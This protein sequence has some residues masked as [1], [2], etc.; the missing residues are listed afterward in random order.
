MASSKKTEDFIC[1]QGT[2]KYAN[3]FKIKQVPS[4]LFS[5]F[6]GDEILRAPILSD[7]SLE[8]AMEAALKKY[9]DQPVPWKT[10]CAPENGAKKLL[11]VGF[12]DDEK[13]EGLK[14][15]EDRSLVK[16]RD[17][18]VFLRLPG[19]K[20]SEAVKKWNLYQA[21]S[22]VLADASK[23]DPEKSPFER[24]SGKKVAM[25]VKAAIVKALAKLDSSR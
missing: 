25:V 5:D 9:C 10:E 6:D 12:D 8:N 2:Q 17:R 14:V 20:D 21:P 1:V 11:I 24:L 19:D 22:I 3:H 23:E 7:K 13:G 16:Y 4:V 15:L 18:C